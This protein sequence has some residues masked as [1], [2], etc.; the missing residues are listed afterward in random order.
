MGII[1]IVTGIIAIVAGVIII[2]KSKENPKNI[3]QIASVNQA[4]VTTQVVLDPVAEPKEGL[5]TADPKAA[6][7]K[8]KGDAFEDFVVNLLADWRLKLLDRTQDKVSSAGVVAESCKNP[9]LQ[10]SQKRG[11]SDIDYYLE[12]KYRS[13]WKDGAIT[14]ED[15]QLDRYRQF[16]SYNHRKVLFAIG[17]GGTPSAP[18]SFMLVPLDSVKGNSIKQ[19]NT[20]FAVEPTSSG[21]VEYMNN[22]FLTVFKK[23]RAKKKD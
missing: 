15:W 12:C 14:I 8:E 5:V 11:N 1:L 2:S 18:A 9:D 13:R 4:A 6:S 10:V 21:L 19:I 22:Y 7:A 3:V 20:Q 16:Q 17:V 23:A